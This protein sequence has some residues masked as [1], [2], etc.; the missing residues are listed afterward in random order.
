MAGH[1]DHGKS[2]LVTALTGVRMDRFAEEQRRGITIDLHFAPLV[3]GDGGVAGMIDVPGHE[4]LVR[5]MVAGSSGVDLALLVIAADE[6]IRPQTLEHLAVLEHLRVPLGIPVITKTDL[7][8]KGD[9]E[10]LLAAIADRLGASIVRFE[11][12][13]PTSVRT[14]EGIGELKARI[15]ARSRSASSRASGDLF[16]LPID[17]AFSVAGIGTVVTGTAWSGTIAIGDEV[18][19]LPGGLRG[20]VRSVESH[21]RSL[22]RS[23]PG[24]RTAVG[25]AGTDRSAVNRGNVL[26][27]L[28]DEWLVTSALDAELTLQSDAPRPMGTRTR[29][30]LLVGTAEV[31]ARVL[32]RAPI[33]PGVTGLARLALEQ[34]VVA[35]GGDRFVVRSYSPVIT[36]GG[37]RVL[38]PAP[39]RRCAWPP[40]LAAEDPHRRFQALLERRPGGIARKMLPMLLGIP[41]GDS[42]ALVQDVPGVRRLGESWVSTAV[43]GAAATR[44][45][46]ALAEY[47]ASAPGS[48]GMPL[49]TLRRA[50]RVDDALAQAA[51]GDL[52]SGHNIRTSA[53]T[54]ALADFRVVVTGGEGEIARIVALIDEAGLSPPT[55]AELAV[56]A[57][58]TDL[59]TVLRLAAERGLVTAVE[60]DRYYATRAL[61]RFSDALR[62]AGRA[63]VITPAAVRD[64]LGVSRKYLI[65]L[66]E[67]A[68]RQGITARVPEGR[69]VIE[70]KRTP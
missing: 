3:L 13:L 44:A 58:R 46:A 18:V 47:H 8:T 64:R 21:G 57:G 16:R 29:V 4:D 22:D 62:E 5:T 14:G 30:R 35:R 69:R 6:G 25:L 28:G 9:L 66:L 17:R 65:P 56:R 52:E 1:V 23:E 49:E 27:A 48:V 50:L 53:G 39:P 11:R 10:S 12:P 63:G 31:M 60:R 33:D 24:A 2:A 43:V 67:W 54:A 15:A 37:G 70:P 42:M 41:P 36:I 38:D 40:G 61:E 51:L 26:V 55:I 68:D 34:P 32:P 19:I 7:V 20:R 45:L 59:P